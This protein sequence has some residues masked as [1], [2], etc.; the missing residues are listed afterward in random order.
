MLEFLAKLWGLLKPPKG[1][2]T[3]TVNFIRNSNVVINEKQ[4]NG[5]PLEKCRH[6]GSP[7]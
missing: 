3:T 2:N 7:K 6:C 5:D 4:K 1:K